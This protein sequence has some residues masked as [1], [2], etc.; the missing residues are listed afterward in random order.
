MSPFIL[1]PVAAGVLWMVHAG[2]VIADVPACRYTRWI[3]FGA[4]PGAVVVMLL[5]GGMLGFLLALII[6]LS[7]LGM[8]LL[9]VFLTV[10]LLVLRDSRAK[11]AA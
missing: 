1:L 3:I 11:Q 4:L 8:I 7:W 6:V 2:L 9:E 10:G 5:S